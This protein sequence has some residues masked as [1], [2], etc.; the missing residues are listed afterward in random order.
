MPIKSLPDE[1]IEAS[2]KWGDQKGLVLGQAGIGKSELMV[3]GNSLVI[4]MEGNIKH[5]KC[6]KVP[7]TSWSDLQD[8]YALLIQQKLAGKLAYDGIVFDTVDRVIALAEEQVISLCRAKF[9]SAIKKGLSINTIGDCPEG[10]GWD[11]RKNL[12][13]NMLEKY[14]QLGI[15]VWLIGHTQIKEVKTPTSKID[16]TTI[17]VGGQLGSILLGWPN[18]ILTMEASWQGSKLVRRVHTIPTE[19]REA[20]SHGGIIPDGWELSS[21][22]G[23]SSQEERVKVAQANYA[24]LRS[25][26]TE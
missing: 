17:N 7:A 24:K 10:I 15:A 11:M 13:V 14:H 26:F 2:K 1:P 16:K 9:D 25:Y 5:L 21:V 3:Q 4:D 6:K 20:K 12:I 22:N 19:N 8:I 23:S 18:H